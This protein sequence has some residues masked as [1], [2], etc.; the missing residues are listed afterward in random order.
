MKTIIPILIAILLS[1]CSILKP[2]TIYI[3]KDSLVTKTETIIKDSIIHLPGDTILINIPIRDTI[4]IVKSKR[5]SSMVQV[6]SGKITIQNSCDEKDILITKLQSEIS[7]FQTATSDSV[8]VEV[9]K[10]KH[11]PVYYKITSYMFWV[12]AAIGTA[13][14]LTNKN[15]WVIVVT[16]LASALRNITK[17][18]S[19]PNG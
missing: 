9:K 16:T 3:T 10:V 8:R 19:S 2:E 12:V 4:F 17:K 18:K 11:V 14:F 6:K 7:K 5:S 15:I 13:F 1:S